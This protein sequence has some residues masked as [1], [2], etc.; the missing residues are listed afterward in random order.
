MK[1]VLQLKPELNAM[2]L[3]FG[4]ALLGVA[5]ALRPLAL[6]QTVIN[7]STIDGGGGT[8]TGGVYSVSATIG[9]P[10]AGGARGGGY[11]LSGGFWSVLGV[12]ETLGA[13]ELLI[14]HQ[15]TGIVVSWPMPAT[16]WVLE[17]AAVLGGGPSSWTEVPM[18][19]Q[20]NATHVFIALPVPVGNSFF[21]L[22]RI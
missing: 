21:R 12:V 14:T 20:T 15:G 13:P 6:A 9:Q 11:T 1:T 22:R 10:D 4:F 7:W 8:S 5:W 18:P 2:K 16:G 3:K 17:Q 19:Y